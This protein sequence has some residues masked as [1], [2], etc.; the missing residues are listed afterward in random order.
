MIS[1]TA[2][3][4]LTCPSHGTGFLGAFV[5]YSKENFYRRISILEETV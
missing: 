4:Y 1:K 3:Q 2:L 5:E